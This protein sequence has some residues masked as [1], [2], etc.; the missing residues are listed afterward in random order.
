MW[1]HRGGGID[2]L[3]C[4]GENAHHRGVTSAAKRRGMAKWRPADQHAM[5]IGY[6]I[7]GVASSALRR[8]IKRGAGGISAASRQ[9]AESRQWLAYCGISGNIA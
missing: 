5:C 6:R 4:R 3:G 2:N 8:G 7:G 1:R 9:R